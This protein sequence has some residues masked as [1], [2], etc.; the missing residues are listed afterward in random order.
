MA[1]DATG[2]RARGP[3]GDMT[4]E[5]MIAE[6]DWHKAVEIIAAADE[7]ALACHISPDGDALGSMLGVGL[8]LRAAGRRVVAS[9]GDRRF[10]VPRLLSFLPGQDLLVEP[11]RYPAEPAVMITFDAA[12]RDRLGLLA[13]NASRSDRLIVVDHHPSN[14]GFGTLDLIDPSASA[15]AMLA[16]ELIRRLGVP[17][18]RDI[19]TCLYTGLVTD[20]G[21]FRHSCTT[22]DAHAMA[23]RLIATGVRTEEIARRLWD[24][25]PFGYLK[26][27][28]AVLGRVELE[29]GAAGGGGLVWTFVT[30]ADREAHGLPYDEIE[31]I[32][33]VI[34]RAD[35][36]EVA[37]V[38][39]ED[40]DGSWQVSTRSKGGVD[41]SRVCAELGGGGHARAAGFTS[42][43]PVAETMRRLRSVLN[44]REPR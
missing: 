20:T 1:T 13:A 23:G 42:P 32:I 36:A 44:G 10:V 4:G 39:K 5:E 2:P 3:A 41:V 22:P 33:D 9:F 12:T 17:L 24:R 43:E 8:A 27:L 16:E 14:S 35:E 28:G 7:V 11:E 37:V 30:R 25:A 26:V 31:G 40:D 21:S 38:L 15:T 18:D 6:G 19:A 34:R 29:P